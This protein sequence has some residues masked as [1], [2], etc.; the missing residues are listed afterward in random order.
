M[1]ARLLGDGRKCCC[2]CVGEYRRKRA[3]LSLNKL[4]MPHFA[5]RWSHGDAD[6]DADAENKLAQRHR[7]S[8]SAPNPE[9]PLASW[10]T[11]NFEEIA[12]NVIGWLPPRGSKFSAAVQIRGD[13][14]AVALC[15][16]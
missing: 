14:V 13:R 7:S 15:F 11:L 9:S 5:R 12:T 4:S 10:I 3:G 8:R 1:L 16:L 6:A 2:C